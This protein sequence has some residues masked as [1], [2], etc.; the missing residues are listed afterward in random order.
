MLFVLH[1]HLV[2]LITKDKSAK[3]KIKKKHELP[4]V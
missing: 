3:K 1:N 4:R 2:T